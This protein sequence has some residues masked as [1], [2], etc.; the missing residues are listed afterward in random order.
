MGARLPG[1]PSPGFPRRPLGKNRADP[2]W[3]VVRTGS[4]TRGRTQPSAGG[5]GDPASHP[6]R[7]PG[8][9]H[10]RIPR[11]RRHGNRSSPDRNAKAAHPAGPSARRV[12]CH[13]RETNRY[14]RH[15][16]SRG[17]AADRTHAAPSLRSHPQS[18]RPFPARR[19]SPLFLHYGGGISNLGTCRMNPC[20]HLLI[21]SLDA[22]LLACG[23]SLFD[24]I[25]VWGVEED[26]RRIGSFD[27]A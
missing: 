1:I 24:L 22:S 12:G 26:D 16:I 6:S 11:P 10:R 27:L 18:S 20:S 15:R 19:P 14:L 9:C 2:L 13:R 3:R 4:F 21:I 25:P 8:L 7:L 23:I 17:M 5:T